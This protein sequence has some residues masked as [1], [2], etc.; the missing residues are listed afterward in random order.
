MMALA[1]E[2]SGAFNS[3]PEVPVDSALLRLAELLGA[4]LV[5]LDAERRTWPL[6]D[7]AAALID[8]IGGGYGEALPEC[9]VEAVDALAEADGPQAREVVIPPPASRHVAVAALR[10]GETMLLALRD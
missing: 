3:T 10:I 1:P 2:T 8:A 4:G 6:N 9:L 7:S 5:R